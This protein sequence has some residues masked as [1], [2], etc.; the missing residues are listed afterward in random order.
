MNKSQRI[1]TE[2]G[3][4]ADKHIK[5]RLEKNVDTLEILSLNINQKDNYQSFNC[6]F[7]VLVGRVNANGSVGVPN[8]KV[9]IFIPITDEDAAN[10]NIKSIY[11]YTNP[12]DK[13]VDGKRYNL[14]PRV[15]TEKTDGIYR[16]RQPFGSFPT[17]QEIVTNPDIMD[18][19]E[20]YYKFSTLTN[21]SGDY[22]LFGIPIGV[23][24]VHMSVDVTDIGNY[25]MS[26]A[27]MV[28]ELGYSPN[29]FN[30]TGTRIKES[31]DL[32]DLPNIETQEID[33]DIIPFCGDGDNFDIGISRQDFR[34]NARIVSTFILFGSCFADS[35]KTAWGSADGTDLDIQLNDYY[36]ATRDTT[37][38]SYAGADSLGN[39]IVPIISEKIYYLPPS[40]TNDDIDTDN[41]GKTSYN[42]LRD[43]EYTTYKR[44]GDFIFNITCNRRKII[45][46]EFG[47]EQEVDADSL[48]GVFTEFKGVFIFELDSDAYPVDVT[49]QYPPIGKAQRLRFKFPQSSSRGDSFNR[50]GTSNTNTWARQHYTFKASKYY[51]IAKFHGFVTNNFNDASYTDSNGFYAQDRINT[52]FDSSGAV[53]SSKDEVINHGANLI[54]VGKRPSLLD[55][56]YEED[57]AKFGL[58]Y[59][60]THNSNSDY[61]T[62]GG[63]WLNFSLHFPNHLFVELE[64]PPFFVDSIQGRY[65]NTASI[66]DIS[67]F[68]FIF[69]NDQRLFDD[70][71]NTKLLGR[72]DLHYTD[73]IEV[74]EVD[75][76]KLANDYDTLK[77]FRDNEVDGLIGTDYRN[78]DSPDLYNEIDKF[79]Y[80]GGGGK[81]EVNPT[82]D[83]DPRTYFFKGLGGADCIN[84]LKDLGF[85][86]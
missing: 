11:P 59:N 45:T 32:E 43:S 12:R 84:Y 15:S 82:N 20:K 53:E 4:N 54:S 7:G 6:D 49:S 77:G 50:F 63:N 65:A 60:F 67:S 18:V 79:P 52:I 30:S 28:N 42:K 75:I 13:N 72:S 56:N 78:A 35:P 74:P 64:I 70:D 31:D 17:K 62:F 69:D 22:M 80:I 8:A 55:G 27:T 57:N 39:K 5:V 46:D 19:Y 1:R 33:V 68:H 47:N 81:I 83:Y 85:I 21:G 29:L 36:R 2:V 86:D 14:L 48:D 37:N 73:F 10:E 58:P 61:R 34:I 76:I 40:V 66:S 44:N 24:T 51:S 38:I 3:T 26:P 71:V 9:S 16:P 25:S 41:F 23:Q